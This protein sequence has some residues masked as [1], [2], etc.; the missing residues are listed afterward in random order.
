[1]LT[2]PIQSLLLPD[3]SIF[4]PE[5]ADN[6]YSGNADSAAHVIAQLAPLAANERPIRPLWWAQLQICSAQ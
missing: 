1:M 5:N 3:P 6:S 4:P 2:L